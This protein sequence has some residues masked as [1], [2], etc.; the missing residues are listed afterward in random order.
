MLGWNP[1]IN[2]VVRQTQTVA[3]IQWCLCTILHDH[4]KPSRCSSVSGNIFWKSHI[5]IIVTFHLLSRHTNS[6][7]TFRRLREQQIITTCR[8]NIFIS[9]CHGT[10]NSIS[11]VHSSLNATIILIN[12]GK[13][14]LQVYILVRDN[15]NR[16]HKCSVKFSLIKFIF[17]LLLK[18]KPGFYLKLEITNIGCYLNR[19]LK[20]IKIL[21]FRYYVIL[22][23]YIITVQNGLK[24]NIEKYNP[25]WD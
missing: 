11:R 20:F 19:I 5:E 2:V 13:R 10:I 8:I 21:F 23:I 7:V 9:N 12:E 14:Y 6:N 4:V 3:Y 25:Q 16:P 1:Y 17:Y 24:S 15:K 22:K 18:K